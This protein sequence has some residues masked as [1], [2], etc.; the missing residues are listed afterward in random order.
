MHFGRVHLLFRALP[1]GPRPAVRIGRTPAG[2]AAITDEGDL[3]VLT[4]S[5]RATVGLVAHLRLG[6]LPGKPPRPRRA[7]A[8]G[9]PFQLKVWQACHGMQTG[10]TITYG[11][12]ARQV[13]CRSPR[14]IG[15][16]LG[17]NP[18]CRL[19]PCHRVTSLHGLGGFAWGADLKRR[20]LRREVA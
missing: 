5:R 13:R 8:L 18:L 1:T 12:L 11:E 4:P 10:G 2:W 3:L 7:V 9:T 6:R 17:R 14:A 15:Q 19:I 16:A 20:W